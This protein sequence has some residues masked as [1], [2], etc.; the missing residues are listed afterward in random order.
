MIVALGCDSQPLD[1]SAEYGFLSGRIEASP[2]AS[3]GDSLNLT[4]H[5]WNAGPDTVTLPLAD[6]LGLAFDPVVLDASGHIVWDRRV[7]Q[8]LP[9]DLEITRVPPHGEV[10]FTATWNLRDKSGTVVPPATYFVT[11]LL[12]LQR[13]DSVVAQN[14][15][16]VTV[17]Q[18]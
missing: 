16:P 12:F 3:L 10:T 14:S 2:N 1:P 5:I 18:K 17:A 7:A 6:H 9:A 8:L 13:G 11:G 15:M 4:L